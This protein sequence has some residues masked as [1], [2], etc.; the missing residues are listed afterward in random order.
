MTQANEYLNQELSIIK[1]TPILSDE[2]HNFNT[3][4]IPILTKH[5]HIEPKPDGYFHVTPKGFQNLDSEEKQ[6]LKQLEEALFA[7]YRVKPVEGLE[8]K[9]YIIEE[10]NPKTGQVL[11][12]TM[13]LTEMVR[14]EDMK[15]IHA[16][17]NEIGVA[18]VSAQTREVSMM[19]QQ[20]QQALLLQGENAP[21]LI[22]E[23]GSVRTRFGYIF[24][25]ISLL[26]LK[27]IM[28]KK[29]IDEQNKL[30]NFL[31]RAK[32]KRKNKQ[33]MD[34]IDEYEADDLKIS[35]SEAKWLFTPMVL[36]SEKQEIDPVIEKLKQETTESLEAFGKIVNMDLTDIINDLNSPEKAHIY[37]KSN[38]PLSA[39]VNYIKEETGLQPNHPMVMEYQHRV[40]AIENDLKY[41]LNNTMAHQYNKQFH[42]IPNQ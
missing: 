6:I 30:K 38:D 18:A 24:A 12:S 7:R 19:Y 20:G 29:D 42:L 5:P 35:K 34:D 3:F 13:Y 16:K 23:H 21:E 37:E 8:G 15:Y 10:C 39:L 28:N 36:T 25:G 22:H 4:I 26:T 33:S 40:N 1:P 9:S 2:H 11:S 17:A 32:Q 14:E 31:L 41:K 27:D